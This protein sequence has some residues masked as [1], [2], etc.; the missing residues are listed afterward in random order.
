MRDIDVLTLKT[1]RERFAQLACPVPMARH[2]AADTHFDARRRPQEEM[3]I[4]ARHR[5]QPVQGDIEAIRERTQLPF[6][7][8]AVSALDRPELV[9]D[10]RMGRGP[11]HVVVR[12][13]NITCERFER[14]LLFTSRLPCINDSLCSV[15]TP[16]WGQFS[17]LPQHSSAS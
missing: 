4:E 12:D 3:R 17:F 11:I 6:R 8:V 2:V 16:P 1:P 10:W 15:V 5:L 13:P 9:E 14:S 7:K